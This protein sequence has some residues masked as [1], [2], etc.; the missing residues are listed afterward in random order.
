MS[1][2]GDVLGFRNW[3]AGFGLRA[4]HPGRLRVQIFGCWVWGVRV[5][6]WEY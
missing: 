3:G 1:G 6:V 4:E 5:G 2:A